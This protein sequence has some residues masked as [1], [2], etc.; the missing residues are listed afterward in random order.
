MTGPSSRLFYHGTNTEVQLGDTVIWKRFLRKGLRGTVVYIPGLCPVH[1][2]LEFDDIRQWAIQHEDGSISMTIYLPER[3]Q[4]KRSIVFV[5]RGQPT[6]L[7][8]KT[9]IH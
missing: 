3:L 4:P 1:S 7:S 2:D 6:A 8:P 5:A 9:R